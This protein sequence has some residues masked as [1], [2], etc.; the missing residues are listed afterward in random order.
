M[1]KLDRKQPKPNNLELLGYGFIEASNE[2][3]TQHPYGNILA[4]VGEAE[5]KLGETEKTFVHKSSDCL[6]QPLK[7]F[8]DGQMKTIQ[9]CC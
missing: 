9:V 8:L 4:K 2:V 3:G 7:S 5:K 6:L 1:T